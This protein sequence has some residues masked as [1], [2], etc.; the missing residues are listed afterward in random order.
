VVEQAASSSNRPRAATNL[1][2]SGR[3]H[4]LDKGKSV[5]AMLLLR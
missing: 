3:G 4:G 2:M 1:W 5:L